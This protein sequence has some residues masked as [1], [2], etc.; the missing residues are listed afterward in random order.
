VTAAW[1]VAVP[2]FVIV[3]CYLTGDTIPN[4]VLR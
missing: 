4:S 2:H 1:P 3:K